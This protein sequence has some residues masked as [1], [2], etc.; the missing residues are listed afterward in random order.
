MDLRAILVAVLIVQSVLPAPMCAG[1]A[2]ACAMAMASRQAECASSCAPLVRPG[3]CC[4]VR[5]GDVP[6]L[7]G[8]APCRPVCAPCPLGQPLAPAQSPTQ[9]TPPEIALL[10]AAAGFQV[11]HCATASPLAHAQRA[12]SLIGPGS[13]SLLCVWVI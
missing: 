5:C 12:S 10:P 11:G 6:N 13:R 1:P 3:T 4:L 9:P 2:G 8:E 7:A